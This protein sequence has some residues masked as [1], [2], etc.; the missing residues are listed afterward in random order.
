M[1]E[2]QVQYAIKPMD[3]EAAEQL[4]RELEDMEVPGSMS[5]KTALMAGLV[6]G[7]AMMVGLLGFLAWREKNRAEENLNPPVT[8]THSLSTTPSVTAPTHSTSASTSASA[9]V[10]PSVTATAP[11][12]GASA[13]TPTS[14]GTAT[15][16][17][18]PGD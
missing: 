1:S 8:P 18:S 5:P 2:D 15:P 10:T 4:A 11:T 17:A 14:T 12:H 3:P 9:S 16:S 7:I 6:L 13:A